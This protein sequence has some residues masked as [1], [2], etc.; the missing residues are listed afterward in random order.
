MSHKSDDISK[1]LS[2]LDKK[3]EEIRNRKSVVQNQPQKETKPIKIDEKEEKLK[4]A[5]QKANRELWEDFKN[6]FMFWSFLLLLIVMIMFSMS[7]TQRTTLIEHLIYSTLI[8]GIAAS[9][10]KNYKVFLPIAVSS[11]IYSYFYL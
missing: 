6:T 9:K 5:T 3:T 2:K 7:R 4:L 8:G 10:A 11:F 1:A